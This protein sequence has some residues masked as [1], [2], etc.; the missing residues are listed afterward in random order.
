M[1][2]DC[3]CTIQNYTSGKYTYKRRSFT[4]GCPIHD[5]SLQAY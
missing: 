3:T 1:I 4:V 5:K 2:T